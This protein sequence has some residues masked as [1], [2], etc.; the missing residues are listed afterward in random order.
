MNT[1]DRSIRSI[2]T[3]L[4]RRVDIWDCPPD[5]AVL[6]RYYA[7][8]TG[9]TNDVEDLRQGFEKLNTKLATELDRH[10]TIGHAF[11]LTGRLTRELVRRVW[12]HKIQPLRDEYFFDAPRPLSYMWHDPK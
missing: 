3:A 1:A 10:H 5:G 12:E 11:F 8:E 2:D 4:R 6:E 7:H 9:H